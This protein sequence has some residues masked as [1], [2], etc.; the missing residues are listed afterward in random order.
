MH[1]FTATAKATAE[2]LNTLPL[3][4]ARKLIDDMR[5]ANVSA[6]LVVYQQVFRDAQYNAL[7]SLL[8]KRLFDSVPRQLATRGPCGNA[9]A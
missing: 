6:V 4:R 3:E 2:R 5:I 9:N 7:F 1:Q 8:E